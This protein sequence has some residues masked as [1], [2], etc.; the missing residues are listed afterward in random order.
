M[1]TR[2]VAILMFDDVEVLDFAG[3]FEVFSVTSELNKG[4]SLPLG[5]V[6]CIICAIVGGEFYQSSSLKQ[7]IS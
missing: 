3:F 2:K 7:T 6:N 1:A 4:D 5:M